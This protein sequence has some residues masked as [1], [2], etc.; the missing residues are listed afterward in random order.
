MFWLELNREAKVI[1]KHL[2]F[3]HL[4]TNKNQSNLVKHSLVN[5]YKLVFNI[6]KL[7]YTLPFSS[8]KSNTDKRLRAY[9]SLI[10]LLLSLKSLAVNISQL[11]KKQFQSLNGSCEEVFK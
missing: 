9:L 6:N 7:L 8:A 2:L 11:F 1:S 4:K 3:L 5:Y 10:E